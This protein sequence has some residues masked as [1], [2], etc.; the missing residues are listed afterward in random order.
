PLWKIVWKFLKILK[1]E[2]PYGLVIPL[3]SIY[4]KKMKAL[5]HKDTCSPLFI[6][7]L[8]TVAKIWKQP[9]CPLVDEW[10]KDDVVCIMEY[11]SAIE[12]NEILSFVTTWIDLENI[13]LN[14]ISQT[15]TNTT[16]FYLYVVSK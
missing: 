5:I 10:K 7:T 4:T 13:I 16:G 2:I 14:E 1:I 11:Y 15:K 12:K 9:K 3:L 8:F 6:S